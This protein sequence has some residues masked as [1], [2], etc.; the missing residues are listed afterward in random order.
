M[1]THRLGR[2]STRP[3]LSGGNIKGVGVVA[4]RRRGRDCG[5]HRYCFT[6]RNGH[7]SSSRCSNYLST[8]TRYAL[9]QWNLAAANCFGFVRLS[10]LQE[11][12]CKTAHLIRSDSPSSMF[13][14]NLHYASTTIV[15]LFRRQ[16]LFFF[17]RCYVLSLHACHYTTDA[18]LYWINGIFVLISTVFTIDH[19]WTAINLYGIMAT[20]HQH[21]THTILAVYNSRN[22]LFL[23]LISQTGVYR[24]EGKEVGDKTR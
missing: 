14:H 13:S 18:C 10:P 12:K 17:S 6:H 9:L 8:K 21:E 3:S 15:R 24:V 7:S 23:K 20:Y 19:T 5:H 11:R 2:E 22:A 16:F 1:V 4:S